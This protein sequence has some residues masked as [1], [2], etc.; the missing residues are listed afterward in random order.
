MKLNVW[1]VEALAKTMREHSDTHPTADRDY[2]EV[3]LRVVEDDD[4]RDV[5]VIVWEDGTHLA[6]GDNYAN[7]YTDV[8]DRYFFGPAVVL[9]K[10]TGRYFFAPGIVSSRDAAREV[11]REWQSWVSQ[12]SLSYGELLGW[13]TYFEELGARFDLTD[14]FRENG[15]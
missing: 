5:L 12:Q 2:A 8:T 11:A 9:S 13:Q 3:E 15:I 4:H 6:L 1:Q 7:Q 14:E 10:D